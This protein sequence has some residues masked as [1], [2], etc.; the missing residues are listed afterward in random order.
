M[1]KQRA[2]GY[3]IGGGQNTYGGLL[4]ISVTTGERAYYDWPCFKKIAK[5]SHLALKT[6]HSHLAQ[7]MC[8]DQKRNCLWLNTK[9]D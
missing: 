9:M 2:C 5:N 3:L 8:F 4:Q 7:S 6:L 1:K